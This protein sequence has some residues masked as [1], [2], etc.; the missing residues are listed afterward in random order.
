MR[1]GRAAGASWLRLARD[2]QRQSQKAR[3]CAVVV[4]YPGPEVRQPGWLGAK[5]RDNLDQCC[6]LETGLVSLTLPQYV[7]SRGCAPEQHQ[8][9]GTWKR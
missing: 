6:R 5:V 1:N 4:G 7:R 2:R 8:D 9:Q 3:R